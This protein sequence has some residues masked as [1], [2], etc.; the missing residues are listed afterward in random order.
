MGEVL[1]VSIVAIRINF[2]RSCA[3]LEHGEDIRTSPAPCMPA[4]IE[5]A[6]EVHRVQLP[7]GGNSRN[8]FVETGDERN[9]AGARFGRH[10]CVGDTKR[11]R[12]E[13]F[14]AQERRQRARGLCEIGDELRR[15]GRGRIG[16]GVGK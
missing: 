13:D 5:H 10:T 14:G 4:T 15:V 8:I 12:L 16:V 1:E 3:V 9:V 6:V 7:A 2:P 11:A